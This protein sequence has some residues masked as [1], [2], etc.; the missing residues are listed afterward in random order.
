MTRRDERGL[1]L[2]ELVIGI[3]IS[4]LIVSTLGMA[5]VATLRNSAAA[6][7]QQQATQQR[8]VQFPAS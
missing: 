5:V 3:A 2:I 8:V 6:R 1:G 7:D 4:S